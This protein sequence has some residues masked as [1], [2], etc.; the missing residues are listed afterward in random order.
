MEVE[1]DIFTV[2]TG[3]DPSSTVNMDFDE[4]DS[5]HRVAIRRHEEA[6]EQG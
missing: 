2:F 6:N 5:W 1:A 3:W 4:L